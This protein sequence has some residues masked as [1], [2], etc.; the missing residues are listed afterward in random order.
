MTGKDRLI[1]G[2]VWIVL[3]IAGLAVAA[4]PFVWVYKALGVEGLGYLVGILG[5]T[6]VMMGVKGL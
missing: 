6:I 1:N 2:I 4:I 3:I 5:M